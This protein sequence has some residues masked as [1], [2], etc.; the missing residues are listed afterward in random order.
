LSR[1]AWDCQERLA[2]RAGE[3]EDRKVS[4]EDTDAISIE[5]NRYALFERARELGRH[6][7]EGGAWKTA[8]LHYLRALA[9]AEQLHSKVNVHVSH[10][11]L[12]VVARKQADDAEYDDAEEHLNTAL[13]M[14]LG[15]GDVVSAAR[16]WHELGSLAKDRHELAKAADYL[17][18]ARDVFDGV[19]DLPGVAAAEHTLGV[20]MRMSATAQNHDAEKSQTFVDAEHHLKRSLAIDERL[21]NDSGVAKTYQQL[22]VLAE[23]RGKSFTREQSER[24]EEAAA[25]YRRALGVQVQQKNAFGAGMI[26]GSLAQLM[27]LRGDLER[28]LIYRIH[29]AALI[30]EGTAAAQAQRDLVRVSRR[31]GIGEVEKAWLDLR[32]TAMPPELRAYL[33]AEC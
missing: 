3:Y 28:E 5:A 2:L 13:A 8:K 20:V 14:C 12:G 33:E 16:C 32:K 1:W 17:C 18:K 11:H 26:C 9:Y 21:S 29:C 30:G 19:P 23:E 22:G 31:A 15:L 27:E 4:A 24:F 7:E 10:Y 6:A 25:W